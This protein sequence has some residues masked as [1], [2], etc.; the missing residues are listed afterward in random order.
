MSRVGSSPSNSSVST[1]NHLMT[2]D[3]SSRTWLPPWGLANLD[4]H[5]NE[6]G[7]WNSAALLMVPQKFA[8]LRQISCWQKFIVWSNTNEHFADGRKC[9]RVASRRTVCPWTRVEAS[10]NH[11]PATWVSMSLSFSRTRHNPSEMRIAPVR[12]GSCSKCDQEVRPISSLPLLYGASL[13]FYNFPSLPPSLGEKLPQSLG[14]QTPF[15]TLSITSSCDAFP[16]F[17]VKVFVSKLP[18][19]LLAALAIFFG[20]N[21]VAAIFHHPRLILVKG[22]QFCSS[23]KLPSA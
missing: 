18:L 5:P 19:V 21:L 13:Y 3:G 6:E 2:C 11:A 17:V 4:S 8:L 14:H 23:L 1:W 10:P 22:A 20:M 15:N 7:K 9:G 16:D 12:I